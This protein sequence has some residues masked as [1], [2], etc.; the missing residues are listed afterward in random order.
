MSLRGT[1]GTDPNMQHFIR[2]RCKCWRCD[3]C[4]P[5]NAN[6]Y[7]QLIGEA[8][9]RHG[10]NKM[11]TLTLDPGKLSQAEH[12]EAGSTRYINRV[13]SHL[14]TY[15]KRYFGH[16]PEYIRV[17]EY[18]GNG[19]AHLHIL[20]RDYIPQ[21]WLSDAWEALGGGRVVDIRQVGMDRAARYVSKYITKDR[22]LKAPPKARR[23]TTS[24]GIKL[25]RKVRTALQW[26]FM[27][28]SLDRLLSYYE[29]TASDIAYDQE[30]TVTTFSAP[31]ATASPWLGDDE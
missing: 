18:Q 20:L 1:G 28:V 13:W 3:Y 9:E 10:L 12:G 6:R 23:V 17:L 11:A 2:T 31:R 24:R 19:N 25:S 5:K 29:P 22:L 27:T 30:G 15:L 8:A 16:A 14:R 4:A 7:R 26:Q 21:A